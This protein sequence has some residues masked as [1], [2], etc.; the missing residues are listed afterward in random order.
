[1]KWKWRRS[2]RDL[3]KRTI[4]EFFGIKKKEIFIHYSL[5]TIPHLKT[6]P[7]KYKV[8]I[9]TSRLRRFLSSRDVIIEF[10]GIH[11]RALIVKIQANTKKCTI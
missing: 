6:E 9:Q 3:V 4:P 8:R 2:G 1:M 10:C 11:I 5:C 7:Q